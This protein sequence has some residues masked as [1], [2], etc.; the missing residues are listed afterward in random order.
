MDGFYIAKLMKT[1]DG[2][3][4]E[5]EEVEQPVSKK[6]K[7]KNQVS[8]T[9]TGKNEEKDESKLA[10][11]KA[12]KVQVSKESKKIVKESDK[13]LKPKLQSLTSEEKRAKLALIKQKLKAKKA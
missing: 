9:S 3:K 1:K 12:N 2:I 11:G 5:Y 10:K 7:K 13:S 4:K 6:N 8:M